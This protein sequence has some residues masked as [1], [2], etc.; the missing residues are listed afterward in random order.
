MFQPS[1]F[2]EGPSFNPKRPPPPPDRDDIVPL[3]YT[4]NRYLCCS[5][6]LLKHIESEIIAYVFNL[7]FENAIKLE[8]FLRR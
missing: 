7:M 1:K 2:A 3:T 6:Y 8:V 5:F 4:S